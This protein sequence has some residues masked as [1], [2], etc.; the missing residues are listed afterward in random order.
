M[1]C[2]VEGCKRNSRT[3]G[4]CQRHYM[5]WY[6]H[7]HTVAT[8]AEPGTG[9]IDA[10]G[11]HRIVLDGDNTREHIRVA[12]RALGH[13]LP[14]GAQVHHVDENRSNNANS[15]LVICPSQGYHNL[16]HKRMRALAAC[17]HADWEKCA[18][19]KLYDKPTNLRG[20]VKRYH[21]ECGRTA[22]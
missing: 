1:I 21:A 9:T 3:H 17:G 4:M 19:C 6:R 11:Y 2:S 8:R 12:E 15:N 16:L 7:G 13:T 18:R 20:Q 5:R 22:P 10:L 14:K